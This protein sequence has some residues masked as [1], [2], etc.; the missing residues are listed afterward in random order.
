MSSRNPSPP[1][2]KFKWKRCQN[3]IRTTSTGPYRY[4]FDVVSDGSSHW[5][6][7]H[8]PATQMV[9]VV[10]TGGHMQVLG[11]TAERTPCDVWSYTSISRMTSSLQAA[12]CRLPPLTLTPT[13][14]SESDIQDRA[15][16]F[17]VHPTEDQGDRLKTQSRKLRKA[18]LH[19][20]MKENCQT[21]LSV[22]RN[23][24]E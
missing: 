16:S 12:P 23:K 3:G 19:P 18:E 7:S 6:P 1:S 24:F 22:L 20:I 14:P 21:F 13:R 9:V 5:V 11:H 2:P 17:S 10:V 8:L 15:E 4:L